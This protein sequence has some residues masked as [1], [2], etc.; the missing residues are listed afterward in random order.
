[1]TKHCWT[2]GIWFFLIMSFMTLPTPLYGLYEQ[3]NKFGDFTVTLVFAAY[4]IGVILGLILM[5]HVSD[6]IG[7]RPVLI[8]AASLVLV[9]AV[10]FAVFADTGTLL[11]LRFISGFA[12]GA[13]SSAATAY[14]VELHSRSP[15]TTDPKLGRLIGSAANLGGLAFGPFAAGLLTEFSYPLTTPYAVYAV[16]IAIATLALFRVPETV[17]QS[18]RTTPWSYRPQRTIIDRTVRAAFAGAATAAFA[19]FAVLGFVTALTSRFVREIADISTPTTIGLVAAVVLSGGMASQILCFRQPRRRQLVIG[20]GCVIAGMSTVLVAALIGSLVTYV[21]GGFIATGGVGLVFAAAVATV[22]DLTAPDRRSGTLA[23]LFLA[24]YIGTTIPVIAI[25]ALLLYF[26][27]VPV[28]VGF[29]VL[30]AVVVPFGIS[31]LIRES[32]RYRQPY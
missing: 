16:I 11:A 22:T 7:R 14:L 25:G 15:R 30:T 26:D 21:V 18:I 6:H 24:A 29:A 3:R 1:M 20:A 31:V 9:T 23:T 27:L 10:G 8:G 5:G 28:V 2:T 13:L 19:G 32:D 17:P 4:G 12:V